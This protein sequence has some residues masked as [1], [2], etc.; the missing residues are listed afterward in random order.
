MP[1]LDTLDIEIL[2]SLVKNS[3]ITISLLAKK[4]GTSI[5]KTTIHYRISRLQKEN[6][7]KSFTIEIN[8]EKIGF[9][10]L[11][12]ILATYDPSVKISQK[13]LI[14][15]ISKIPGVEEVHVITGEWDLLI[16]VRARNV[17]E[18]GDLI[19]DKLR[20]MP[21]ILRTMTCMVLHSTGFGPINILDHMEKSV[22]ERA[23][24]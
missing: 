24:D 22:G 18:L 5:P 17:R 1:V 9:P 11:A 16:K 13:K 21:G 14:E 6:V 8:Y 15:H 10:V 19:V 23:K 2:K 3:K 20:T 12:Y 4:I 7:I